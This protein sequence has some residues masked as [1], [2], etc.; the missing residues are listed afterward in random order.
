MQVL[1]QR[2][3]LHKWWGEALERLQK[4]YSVDVVQSEGSFNA[5][6]RCIHYTRLLKMK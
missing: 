1:Q 5:L 2:L 4:N 3:G 6:L